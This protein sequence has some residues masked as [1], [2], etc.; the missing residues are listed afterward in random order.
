[1]AKTFKSGKLTMKLVGEDK[2]AVRTMNFN[3]M[4]NDAPEEEILKVRSAIETLVDEPFNK[5]NVTE[6]YEIDQEELSYGR[7]NN[8]EF[9]ITN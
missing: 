2:K 1:M 3:N 4:M 5:T 6:N 7:S 9:R 8:N